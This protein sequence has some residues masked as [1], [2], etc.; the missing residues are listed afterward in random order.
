MK[1]TLTLGLLLYS[2]I[3]LAAPVTLDFE[4]L[5]T[6]I[7]SQIEVDGFR[8]EEFPSYANPRVVADAGGNQSLSVGASY[9]GPYGQCDYLAIVMTRVDGGAFSFFGADTSVICA[10]EF[11]VG[12]CYNNISGTMV[13]GG[14]ASGPIGT[15]D[16][17]YLETVVFGIS[18]ATWQPDGVFPYSMSVDNVVVSAVPIPPAAWLMGSALAG[19]GWLRRKTAP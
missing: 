8:F 6:G 15:A 14:T 3:T 2:S 12:D 10:G 4:G 9:C 13:G 5:A 7:F 11:L 16:W 18:A 19:L 1:R 17:L